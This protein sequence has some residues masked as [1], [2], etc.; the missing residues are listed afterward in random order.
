MRDDI[1][2]QRNVLQILADFEVC[3]R[4]E[5]GRGQWSLDQETHRCPADCD[6]RRRS[7]KQTSVLTLD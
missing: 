2:E 5:T 4:S 7:L 6:G 3:H 1:R